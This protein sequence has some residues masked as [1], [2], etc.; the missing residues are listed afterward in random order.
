MF[1]QLFDEPL[2]AATPPVPKLP[3][4]LAGFWP[5]TLYS[6]C[7]FVAGLGDNP[8]IANSPTAVPNLRS[9]MPGKVLPPPVPPVLVFDAIW[10][11]VLPANPALLPSTT[12]MP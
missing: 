6:I 8:T 4:A 12:W 2:P 7:A 11:F 9:P 3:D 10:R 1:V 5:A